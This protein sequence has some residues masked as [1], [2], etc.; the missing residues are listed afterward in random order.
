MTPEATGY[1][2]GGRDLEGLPNVTQV[3]IGNL[4]GGVLESLPAGQP[5]V[6]LEAK[7]RRRH[8][9]ASR[10]RRARRL[11]RRWG[12]RRLDHAGGDEKGAPATSSPALTE[13]A[14]TAAAEPV[15]LAESGSFRRPGERRRP[16][17]RRAA[18]HR[19]RG[20]R[21]AAARQSGQGLAQG[22]ARRRR[23][24]GPAAW[25]SVSTRSSRAPRRPIGGPRR[26]REPL[27]TGQRP[28]CSE[29]AAR[30]GGAGRA[31]GDGERV[32]VRPGETASAGRVT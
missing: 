31:A 6:L 19:S 23:R 24:G 17:R 11:S 18:R 14:A 27:G 7:P 26:P 2:A 5:L 30:P 4:T 25:G 32:G 21:G 10:R 1:G 22:G 15:L 8:R 13:P 28:I 29:I 20:R 12:A 16:F 3:V 9:R